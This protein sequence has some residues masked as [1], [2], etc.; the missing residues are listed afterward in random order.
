[1]TEGSIKQN[2]TEAQYAA[3]S[4]TGSAVINIHHHY[5]PEDIRATSEAPANTLFDDLPCPYRGLFA[6]QEKDARFFFGREHFIERLVTAVERKPLVA[7]IGASGSGK[8]SLVFAGLIPRLRQQEGWLILDFRPED[9]PFHN[10]AAALV[11]LLEPEMSEVDRL[12]EVKKLATALSQKDVGLSDTVSRILEKQSGSQLLLIVDQFEELYTLSQ[13]EDKQQVFLD[14][15]L[16]AVN[17][18]Q[19]FKLVLTLRADFLGAA[20]SYPPFADALQDADVKLGLMNRQ[21]LKQAI[22]EPAKLLGVKLE[23][24]LTDRILDAVEGKSGNL[25]LLGFALEKLWAKQQN[26]RLIHQAYEDIG[27]V[28]MALANYADDEYRK[29]TDAERQRRSQQVFVQLVKFGE[30]TEDTRR[31]ATRAEVGEDNWDIVTHFA[32]SR[33]VITGSR[34][35]NDASSDT[36]PP[37][38]D[39]SDDEE[40]VE[41]IHEAL[42]QKWERLREWIDNDRQFRTWQ[43]RLRGAI[44]QWN[45]SDRDTGALLRGYLLG[46]AQN[47]QEKYRTYLTPDER[48]YIEIS[49]T[50]HEREEAKRR[51]EEFERRILAE[52]NQTLET[53]NQKATKK[54]RIGS[55]F[56]AGSVLFAAIFLGAAAISLQKRQEAEE[57]TRLEQ[58]GVSALRQFRSGELEALQS[59]MHSAERLQVLVDEDTPPDKYPAISPMLALQKIIDTIHERNRFDDGEDEIKVAQFSPDGEMIA[60]AGREGVVKLRT[61]SGEKVGVL[62]G[63]TPGILGGINDLAFSRDGKRIVTAGGDETVLL[64]NASGEQTG[65]IEPGLSVI[66]SVSISPDGKTVA[67]A[68]DFSPVKLFDFAGKERGK[69]VGDGGGVN[70]IRFSADGQKIV[71]AGQDGTVRLWQPSGKAISTLVKQDGKSFLDARFSPDDRSVVVVGESS[72]FVV[73]LANKTRIPLV[74]HT[75]AVISATFS[76]DGRTIATGGDDGTIRLWDRQGR[77]VERFQGHRGLVWQLSFSPDGRYLVSAGRDGTSR[78]WQLSRDSSLPE[79]SGFKQDVNEVAFMPDGS[80]IVG[81]GDEG[82]VRVW[83]PDGQEQKSWMANERGTIWGIDVSPDGQ[84]IATAGYE[85]VARLWNRSGELV[86]TLQGHESWVNDIH[87]SPDGTKLLT[88]GAD[89]TARL[90]SRSGEE[91]AVLA[92][93]EEV[94]GKVDFSPDGKHI[95]TTAWDGSIGLW[96]GSG[97]E[98]HRWSGHQTQIRSVTFSAD[99]KRIVTADS[100]SV[101]KVWDLAG[102]QQLE[103]FSYQSGVNE[104]AVSR[105]GLQIAT[106]GMDGTVRIWD[107]QGRQIAEFS[108]E[109]G[110]V[111]G[112]SFSSDGKSLVAGGDLGSVHLWQVQ[113]VDELLMQGCRWL[114]DYLAGHSGDARLREICQQSLEATSSAQKGW[115]RRTD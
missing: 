18:S 37:H 21:E 76:P 111:W 97:R 54:I 7:V 46:E 58:A 73:N 32:T 61:K 5:P 27:G 34:S 72:A 16:E 8:S 25:P 23:S 33:L 112:L 70:R 50:F 66:Q 40:T 38:S 31:L 93:H 102:R 11:P 67:V 51:D 77:E 99:G 88:S 94:V 57:G 3:T 24:G 20:L 104:V 92:G 64:W 100:D 9:R 22:E 113:G 59:A 15:L 19:K 98:I 6:F 110:A 109:R 28:E 96:D 1:V 39:S 91:S 47:W 87:F 4:A 13:E 14:L 41:I 26:A 81:A 49:Q 2:I 90:W 45:A 74:G 85:N 71:T 80:A 103:F 63:H 48:E 75:G 65:K 42:I 78:L 56:L 12:V 69:L 17:S 55:I 83:S 44:R 35:V 36:S 95:V 101:V 106:G 43:D 79:F 52:A 68:G 86:A 89:K 115:Q 114:E 105:D 62:E 82:I 84:T 108:N 29:L 30:G 107:G 53:A 60:T 10:L